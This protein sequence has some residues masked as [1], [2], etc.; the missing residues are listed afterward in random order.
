[1]TGDRVASGINTGEFLDVFDTH[2]WKATQ[3]ATLIKI[4]TSAGFTE[5]DVVLFLDGWN[6]LIESLAYIR[7]AAGIPFKMVGLFHAGTYDPW[8]Y[9]AQK[10][11]WSWA[12]YSE[13]GWFKA[14]DGVCVATQFHAE[15]IQ[16]YR[17]NSIGGI[18]GL[19]VTGFPLLTDEWA[20]HA[21][22]WEQRKRVVVF[23]HRWAPEKNLKDWDQLISLYQDA[24]PDDPVEFVAT[25][26][27]SKTDY[28]R[29]LGA[30]RVVVSTAY[31]ETW[32]IAMLEAVSLG[33]WPV[34][35]DRLSYTETLADFPRY[36]KLTEAVALIRS[37]LDNQSSATLCGKTYENAINNIADVCEVV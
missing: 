37:S 28:Y 29:T 17:T 7:D 33:C 16:R 22:R 23:P 11:L 4:M 14:L 12:Q 36:N 25:K 26:G 20:H 34:A 35:P 27:L 32:G 9:L 10:G 3:A 19:F 24:Y 8:D 30:S 15:M 13:R 31:Q 2:Y 6:P 1:M 5:N 18:S 21:Q